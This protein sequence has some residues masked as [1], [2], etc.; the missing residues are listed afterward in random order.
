MHA[1]SYGYWPDQIDHQRGEHG[2]LAERREETVST[3]AKRQWNEQAKSSGSPNSQSPLTSFFKP[4]D[5]EFTLT[6]FSACPT[7]VTIALVLICQCQY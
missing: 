7:L 4:R 2:W 5:E 3:A 6:L 1:R